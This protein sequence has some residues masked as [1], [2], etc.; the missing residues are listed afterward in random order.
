MK[1]M[2]QFYSEAMKNKTLADE[3]R[4]AITENRL[5]EILTKHEVN[6]TAEEFEAFVKEKERNS[7][8]LSDEELEQAS[9]GIEWAGDG[10]EFKEK[11]VK[12]EF[13]VGETVHV[14]GF[15]SNKV[16]KIEKTD[17]E[18]DDEGWRDI[19]YP[20]Y[21]VRISDGSAAWYQQSYLASL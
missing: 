17:I 16:G 6:G 19:Y 13:R 12:F 5:A 20:V 10:S 4:R 21:Y 3:V 18:I 1:T 15:W 8:E 11:D 9:G 2:E 14:W 7:R